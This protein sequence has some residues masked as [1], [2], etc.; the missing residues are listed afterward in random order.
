MYVFSCTS[1]LNMS[2]ECRLDD[3]SIIG[4]LKGTEAVKLSATEAQEQGRLT[5]ADKRRITHLL[6]TAASH[7]QI[8]PLLVNG[9]KRRD[10]DGL[11][12]PY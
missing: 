6:G 9:S 7:A 11:E 8:S 3:G 5:D 12:V 2:C 10:L 1:P 4:H